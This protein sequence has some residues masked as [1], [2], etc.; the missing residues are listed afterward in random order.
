M[1]LSGCNGDTITLS[2]WKITLQSGFHSDIA[3]ASFKMSRYRTILVG[4][5]PQ[6][7]AITTFGSACSMRL[8]SSL[9][10]KPTKKIHSE[11]P[12]KT[13]PLELKF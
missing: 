4:S 6:L 1:K 9:A 12:C 5:T 7:A 3:K 11:N 10:A 2:R 8:Q 13:L